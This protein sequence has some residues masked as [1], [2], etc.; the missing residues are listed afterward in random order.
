[1]FVIDKIWVTNIPKRATLWDR[2]LHAAQKSSFPFP[3]TNWHQEKGSCFEH[4]KRKQAVQGPKLVPKNTYYNI[5][6]QKDFAR[7][8][9]HKALKDH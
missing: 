4:L 1:M 9:P 7:D 3:Y 6:N 8:A 2:I 5:Y